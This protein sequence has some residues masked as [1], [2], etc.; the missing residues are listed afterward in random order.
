MKKKEYKMPT[1]KVVN[2]D[3]CDII[4]TSGEGSPKENIG[5]GPWWETEPDKDSDGY[6]WAD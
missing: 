2:L 3:S 5:R 1:L 4:C 6:I